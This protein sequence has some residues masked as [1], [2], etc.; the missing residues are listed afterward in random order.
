MVV[1]VIGV[2]MCLFVSDAPVLSQQRALPA[3]ILATSHIL[4]ALR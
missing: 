2:D 3:R 4:N 1:T